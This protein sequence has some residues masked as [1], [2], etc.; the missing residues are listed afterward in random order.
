MGRIALDWKPSASLVLDGNHGKFQSI[1]ER[2]ELD[3]DCFKNKFTLTF[4]PSCLI[5]ILLCC[6]EKEIEVRKTKSFI[7]SSKLE[8]ISLTRVV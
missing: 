8:D 6:I 5:F 7:F 3:V 4:C 2:V 1:A